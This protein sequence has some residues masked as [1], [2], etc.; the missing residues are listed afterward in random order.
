[1]GALENMFFGFLAVTGTSA[2]MT[3]VLARFGVGKN[4]FSKMRKE[5]EICPRGHHF[6]CRVRLCNAFL[7]LEPLDGC[8]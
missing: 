1:M 2:W 3:L 7:I 5:A 6:G 8:S 4:H